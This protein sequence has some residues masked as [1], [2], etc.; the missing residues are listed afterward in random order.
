MS[1]NGKGSEKTVWLSAKG[2]KNIQM[3]EYENDFTFI[4]GGFRHSC[5]RF[6]AQFISPRVSR[7][8]SIDD[9]IS[10]LEIAVEDN[11][12]NFSQLLSGLIDISSSTKIFLISI[13]A[14]LENT[15]LYLSVQ[16]ELSVCNIIDRLLCLSSFGSD[17]SVE[18]EFFAS[19]FNEIIDDQKGNYT[20]IMKVGVST[21]SSI[22]S[23]SSLK[24]VSEDSLY[25]FVRDLCSI[26]VEMNCLFEFV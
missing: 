26:D 15:E 16:D 8:H 6:V 9:T 19:H 24:V 10:T 20:K 17:V 5:P 1:S 21:I 12:R 18:L 23:S 11:G 3:N 7:L 14:A 25:E 13:S 22:L 4:V 2:L